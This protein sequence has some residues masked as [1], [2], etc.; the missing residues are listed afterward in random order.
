[1]Q[2][3]HVIIDGRVQGVGFRYSTQVEAVR[4]D[5]T[6]YVRNRPNG[7]VEI[8]AEGQASAINQLLTWAH[9]GPPAAAVHQVEVTYGSVTGEFSQ[10]TIER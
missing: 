1:M 2:R 9:Q 8:V 7:T 4:L 10:F 6:G 5:L 3:I